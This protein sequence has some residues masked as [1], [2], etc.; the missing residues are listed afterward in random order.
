MHNSPPFPITDVIS[1]SN[2]FQTIYN[3]SYTNEPTDEGETE[4]RR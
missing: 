1:K 3:S 2:M 4:R